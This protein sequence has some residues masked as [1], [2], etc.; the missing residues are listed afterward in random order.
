M[1]HHRKSRF[2]RLF[3]V[4]LEG[5]VLLALRSYSFYVCS[6]SHR[7]HSRIC[8]CSFPLSSALLAL[9]VLVHHADGGL[10]VLGSVVDYWTRCDIFL[11]TGFSILLFTS[12][13]SQ[14]P[15]I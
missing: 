9:K 10:F 1:V 7:V 2:G 4:G 11:M 8:E 15:I 3:V 5:I 12:A 14:P 6:C 13:S